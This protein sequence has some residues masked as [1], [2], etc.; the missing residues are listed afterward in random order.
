[1]VYLFESR[2]YLQILTVL[3]NVT[4]FIEQNKTI[5]ALMEPTMIEALNRLWYEN[6]PVEI[7]QLSQLILCK[8][9]TD[10]EEEDQP[11]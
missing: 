4:T 1:M 10:K 3:E 8:I 11:S 9:T 2:L 7:Q 5:P 6:Y